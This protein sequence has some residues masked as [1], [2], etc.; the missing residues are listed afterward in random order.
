MRDVCYLSMWQL[1]VLLCICYVTPVEDRVCVGVMG[2]WCGRSGVWVSG[3]VYGWWGFRRASEI[4]LGNMMW[5]SLK[6]LL[7]KNSV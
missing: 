2:F 5:S 1:L 7:F 6:W 4:M 3:G